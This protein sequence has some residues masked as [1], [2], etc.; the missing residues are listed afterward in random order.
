MSSQSDI[1]RKFRTN[2]TSFEEI[3]LF[4]RI[5]LLATVLP[6]MLRLISLPKLMNVLTPQGPKP[7]TDM[8]RERLKDKI[9]KF[10]DYVLGHDFW[11]Y[12]RTCLKRSLV[13]YHFLRRFDINVHVCFGVRYNENVPDKEE[14]KKLE[15]HAW[16]LYKGNIFLEKKVDITRTYRVT[17]SF[18]DDKAS[19]G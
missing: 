9:V 14:G 6:V 1:I 3:W 13:L 18:P 7:H 16:L 2:F 11:I 17:Y 5:F 19:I 4:S 15:G 12:R 10:T 8:D